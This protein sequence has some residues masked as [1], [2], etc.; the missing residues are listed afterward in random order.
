MWI[1][2][3]CLL[4]ARAD[5]D[6]TRSPRRGTPH[7]RPGAGKGGGAPRAVGQAVGCWGVAGRGGPFRGRSL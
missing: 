4:A 7:G 1:T 5:E 3:K 2:Q 6:V